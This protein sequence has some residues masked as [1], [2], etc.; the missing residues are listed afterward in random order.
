MNAQ[1]QKSAYPPLCIKV[2]HGAEYKA[3]L[4]VWQV[5]EHPKPFIELFFDCLKDEL[6]KR[7]DFLS[8]DTSQGTDLTQVKNGAEVLGVLYYQP[9][10]AASSLGKILGLSERQVQ[11]ILKAVF[12]RAH[13]AGWFCAKRRMGDSEVTKLTHSL[14]NF[15]Q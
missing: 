14:N 3:A 5:E 2:D 1:L 13:R 6:E 15:V 8:Q 7:I 9:S 12:R 4:E 11:R 10:I